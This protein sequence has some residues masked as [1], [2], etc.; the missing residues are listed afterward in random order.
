[1]FEYKIKIITILLLLSQS[2]TLALKI[3][4]SEIINICAEDAGWPPFSILEK[5]KS[6]QDVKLSGKNPELIKLIFDKNNIKYAIHIKPWKRCLY[7]GIHGNI[8]IVLDA[9]SNEQRKND[10][11]LTDTIYTLTP[12]FVYSSLKMK[13]V[14]SIIQINELKKLG[15]GCGQVGYIYDN[16]GFSNDEL[17][18]QSKDL[19]NLLSLVSKKRCA[20][21]LAR[22]EVYQYEK[23]LFKNF[24]DIEYGS[25]Q[26]ATSE[27][28]FWLI[29]K[30][31]KYSTVL[32]KL[33]NEELNTL[34]LLSNKK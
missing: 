33:I 11:L 1:M 12:V 9:A 10:Y 21:G 17:N 22:L 27:E 4:D 26:N 18:L 29:N 32:K 15:P 34:S 14:P 25:I 16:F 8:Q 23:E 13:N 31:Y 28:F 3:P 7:E 24:A 5:D 2:F 30:N 20:F 6:N 19:Q